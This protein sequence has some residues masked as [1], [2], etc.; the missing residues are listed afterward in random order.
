[1]DADTDAVL[2]GPAVDGPTP[3][4]DA[5][6][7][8]VDDGVDPGDDEE[9]DPPDG[10]DDALPLGGTVVGGVLLGCELGP[11]DGP[12]APRRVTTAPLGAKVTVLVHD[13]EGAALVTVAMIV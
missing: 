10:L 12:P 3:L 11:D 9:L 7:L 8:G 1:V 4:D 13:P 6:A 2:D 5:L